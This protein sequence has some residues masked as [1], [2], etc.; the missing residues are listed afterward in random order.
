MDASVRSFSKSQ[1]PLAAEEC[2]TTI[3]LGF[4]SE[5]NN[6]FFCADAA[7]FEGRWRAIAHNSL[8]RS[9]ETPLLHSVSHGDLQHAAVA[10]AY[11]YPEQ[12]T[13][14]D[15]P[16][17]PGVIDLSG[18][19]RPEAVPTR[20]EMLKFL[21]DKKNEFYARRG[22]FEY[23]AFLA[24][25]PQLWGRGLGSRL[26]KY[27]T[28]RADAAGRW[29]Y[30][31][32]TSPDNARLYARHGFREIETKVWTLDC[33]PG[34]RMMLILMERPPAQQQQQQQQP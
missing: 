23:V 19:G 9:P 4:A 5:P 2:C 34:E 6:A 12:K 21:G 17:P 16:E 24:T 31:E 27:L 7:L 32:A 22:P 20:D 1:D 11:S 26:L 13:P 3:G 8:L 18:T 14:D 29:T 33:L 25:R 28:D 10:F 30:L 15:A